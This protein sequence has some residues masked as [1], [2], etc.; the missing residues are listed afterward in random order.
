MFTVG[1]PCELPVKVARNLD[2]LTGGLMLARIQ[3]PVLAP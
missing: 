3:L 2:V 1:Y